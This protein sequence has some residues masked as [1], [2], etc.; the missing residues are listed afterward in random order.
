MRLI[1]GIM[2]TKTLKLF[3][4]LI[5]KKKKDVLKNS[6]R[7]SEFLQDM[8]GGDYVDTLNENTGNQLNFKLQSRDRIYLNKLNQALQKI[9]DGSFGECAECSE[10]ISIKRLL[11]RPVAEMCI[12]CKEAAEHQEGN[13]TYNKKSKTHGKVISNNAGA[14]VINFGEYTKSNSSKGENVL[15]LRQFLQ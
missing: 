13:I 5:I 3:K 9:Q 11:A 4:E 10:E 14:E 2:E 6:E 12:C 8:I 1:G 7:K 15:F